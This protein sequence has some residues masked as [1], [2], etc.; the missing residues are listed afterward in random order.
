MATI[1]TIIADQ[2]ATITDVLS[3]ARE[4]TSRIGATYPNLNNPRLNYSWRKPNLEPPP[5]FGEILPPDTSGSTIKFLDAE[6]DKL[7]AKYFPEINACLKDTP[8]RWLCGIITGEKP[9]GL[10]QEAFELAWHQGRDR[11]YRSA[12]SEVQQIAQRYSAAGFT[13]PPG[14]MVSAINQAEE[15]ASDAI[16]EVNRV[17]TIRD[18]ELKWEMLKFAEEQ[19]IMYKLGI[20][21][22]IADYYRQFLEIPNR[23]MEMFRVKAQA[24]AAMQSALASYYQV[25]LGFEQLRLRAEESRA[26][27]TVDTD[28]NKISATNNNAPGAL[29]QAARGFT[30]VASAASDAQSALIADLTGGA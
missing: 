13:L 20:M 7:I 6:V 18:I 5:G 19:A 11:A 24:Y 16:A 22:L 9:L 30:D 25:E 15:R 1:D 2:R 8:E 3:T 26:G 21:R 27:I 10:S 4:V 17:Q 28:R 23:D 12:N 29:A 14:A